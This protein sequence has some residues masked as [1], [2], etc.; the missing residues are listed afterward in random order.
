MD[1]HFFLNLWFDKYD[2]IP[3]FVKE[4]SEEQQKIF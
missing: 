3:F 4:K 2:F 1:L